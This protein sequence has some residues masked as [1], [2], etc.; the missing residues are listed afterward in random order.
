M[1]SSCC[2]D[3]GYCNCY[4]FGDDAHEAATATTATPTKSYVPL[5][6]CYYENDSSVDICAVT[7]LVVILLVTIQKAMILMKMAVILAGPLTVKI[8]KIA[9][10][11]VTS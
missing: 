2:D 4:C 3:D 8:L 6:L 5:P 9:I 10:V 11:A 1:F 7:M